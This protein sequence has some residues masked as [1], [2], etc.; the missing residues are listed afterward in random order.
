MRTISLE[1]ITVGLI[2]F[3][4]W[5]EPNVHQ[6]EDGFVERTLSMVVRDRTA[7]G[8][9]SI[10]LND[11]TLRDVLADWKKG[12]L[13]NPPAG[14]ATESD[15]KEPKDSNAIQDDPDA[16]AL[17]DALNQSAAEAITQRLVITCNGNPV[18]LTA[19]ST[20]LAPRHPFCVLVKF[21]F[22]I[23]NLQMIDLKVTDNNFLQ[24]PGAFRAAIKTRGNATLMRSNV[25]PILVRA[26]R[27]E[28]DDLSQEQRKQETTI[29]AKIAILPQ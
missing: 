13:T 15:A 28:L 9:Y 1:T 17:L 24:Q 8:E 4:G 20:G 18:K 2:I 27:I 7:Y 11:R 29:S 16:S 10:G 26:Q 19:I 3:S 5:I 14:A 22:Q 6:F 23:P 12:D 25:A 21:E